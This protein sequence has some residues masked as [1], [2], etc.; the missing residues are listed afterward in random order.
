MRRILLA[1]LLL[2]V[3]ATAVVVAMHRGGPRPGATPSVVPFD[4]I[5]NE[6]RGKTANDVAKIVLQV[7]GLNDPIAVTDKARISEL[8][9]G[10]REAV[11]LRD[12]LCCAGPVITIHWTNGSKSYDYVFANTNGPDQA[13]GEKFARA[14]NRLVP[15]ASRV[16]LH[17]T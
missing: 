2:A 4:E 13:F 6:V 7:P 3:L 1:L 9:A 12:G 16:K 11:E 14:F 8:L 17:G 15:P 5:R 10:L